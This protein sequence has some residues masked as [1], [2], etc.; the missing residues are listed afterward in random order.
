MWLCFERAAI[1]HARLLAQLYIAFSVFTGWACPFPSRFEQSLENF[2]YYKCLFAIYTLSRCRATPFPLALSSS[3]TTQAHSFVCFVCNC[4]I[5]F[6][7]NDKNEE[8]KKKIAV[9]KKD[10]INFIL[11]VQFV[12]FKNEVQVKT[13]IKHLR[14]IVA[15]SRKNFTF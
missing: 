2:S 5:L 10:K 4:N 14:P 3:Q 6:S 15:I 9:R 8:K 11:L 12:S 7:C 13:S 1:L